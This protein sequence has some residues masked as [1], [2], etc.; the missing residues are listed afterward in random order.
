M[1]KRTSPGTSSSM[2]K[3]KDNIIAVDSDFNF[4]YDRKIDN[5]KLE[6]QFNI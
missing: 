3:S 4:Y 5:L 6:K 2:I 1:R